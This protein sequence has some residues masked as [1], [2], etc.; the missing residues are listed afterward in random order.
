MR[1]IA[2]EIFPRHGAPERIITDR[3]QDFMSDVY[4]EVT[5]L[6]HTKHSPTTP[7]HP[8]TD[9]QCERMIGT[10]TG[11]LAKIAETENNW[12]EQLPFALYTY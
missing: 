2:T 11:I 5:E 6:L 7:Y 1:I 4:R 12:D 10:I 9:G 3:G 8:Q